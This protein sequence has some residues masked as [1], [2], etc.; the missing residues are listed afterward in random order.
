MVGPEPGYHSDVKYMMCV[1]KAVYSKAVI[2]KYEIRFCSERQYVSEDLI[3]HI[4]Y[5]SKAEAVGFLPDRLYYYCVNGAVTLSSTY[6]RDKFGRYK[7]FLAEVDNRLSQIF[8][9]NDYITHYYRLCFLYLRAS[10][11]KEVRVTE[12]LL[13]AKRVVNELES[14]SFFRSM[15]T[16]YPYRMLPMKHRILFFLMKHELDWVTVIILKLLTDR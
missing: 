8:C 10:I 14:D 12:G 15:F 3:F 13:E 6:D 5:L 16:D 4:D 7:V 11:A 2:D 1:W 9:K